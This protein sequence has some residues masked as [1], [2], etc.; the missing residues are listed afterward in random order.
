MDYC[1][2]CPEC[3]W[4]CEPPNAYVEMSDVISYGGTVRYSEKGYVKL[5]CPKCDYEVCAK[6]V[7]E[8][9]S[10]WNDESDN[11]AKENH[12]HKVICERCGKEFDECPDPENYIKAT[13]LDL[14]ERINNPS[15]WDG[16]NYSYILPCCEYKSERFLLK[17]G[18]INHFKKQFK[19]VTLQ[20]EID[21]M[22]EN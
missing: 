19:E 21:D 22:E 17:N 16:M 2:P 7:R 10:K 15:Y 6:S 4:D 14:S 11:N 13:P 20:K 18:C 5:K 3:E 9:V 1:K 12:I 8:A